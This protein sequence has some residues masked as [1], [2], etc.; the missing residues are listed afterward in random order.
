MVKIAS[1]FCER[2]TMIF[3]S[4]YVQAKLAAVSFFVQYIYIYF[5]F[6]FSIYISQ[7]VWKRLVVVESGLIVAK[8]EFF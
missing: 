3:A 4:S 2:M 6:F 1:S 5:L 7:V 8:L